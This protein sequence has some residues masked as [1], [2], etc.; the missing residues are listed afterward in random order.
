MTHTTEPW[1]NS[2]L[3]EGVSHAV[4]VPPGR[5]GGCSGCPSGQTRTGPQDGDLQS[6]TDNGGHGEAGSSGGHGG[7]GSS[8]GH[9]GVAE[10]GALEAMAELGAPEAMAGARSSGGHGRWSFMAV[11]SSLGQ[12]I[13][14]GTLLPPKKIS[15]GKLGGLSSPQGLDKQDST[16][17]E[18]PPGPDKQDRTSHRNQKPSWA[19]LEAEASSGHDEESGALTGSLSNRF[20]IN[21]R[22]A[23]GW[24]GLRG[25]KTR[26][27]LPQTSLQG[28]DWQDLIKMFLWAQ[29]DT[30][31]ALLA[32]TCGLDPRVD[33]I[34]RER[35][36][37]WAADG[38]V[39]S[40]ERRGWWAADGSVISRE[41]RARWAADGS[42]ISRELRARWAADGGVI[43][44]ERRA[45]WALSRCTQQG[46]TRTRRRGRKLK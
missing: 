11:A 3:P 12:A 1:H 30:N 36:G 40:R 2:P 4:T 8:G 31:T 19:G 43:S 37:R 13:P 14:A 10:L 20:H 44:R 9:G 26:S 16:W 5:G 15:L 17:Q 23:G 25:H 22:E 39:I 6:G 28:Q 24:N 18:N 32:V 21:D 34:S 27:R 35:R 41:R 33:W 42:V 7:A 38:G 29:Q 45:R 46:G